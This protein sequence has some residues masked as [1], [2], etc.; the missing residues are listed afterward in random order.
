MTGNTLAIRQFDE[1]ISRNYSS[2]KTTA[3]QI[4]WSEDHEDIL[5]NNLIKIRNRIALSGFTATT[6]NS[7]QRSM[8]GFIW[9]SVSNEFKLK[10]RKESKKRIHSIDNEIL[11]NEIQTTLQLGEHDSQPYHDDMER[12][13]RTLFKYL[14][15]N[16][17]E[18]KSTLFKTYFLTQFKTY[19]KL[20]EQSKL[21]EKYLKR[22]ITRIRED[23]RQNFKEFAKEEVWREVK[24]YEGLYWVSN[25][26]RIKN[27][28]GN[29]LK[30][31][32]KQY[33]LWK[34][35]VRKYKSLEQIMS[36]SFPEVVI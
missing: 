22:I 31:H 32:K 23:I 7:Y 1:Y 29:I 25:K 16:Y 35:Q 2:L 13:T 11:E 33:G 15:K 19:Q 27:A 20:A 9:R 8:F 24:N 18:Q 14:S 6:Y 28:S 21:D 5:H 30:P 36:G 3:Q 26:G 34:Q 10:K 4:C 17:D 12:F